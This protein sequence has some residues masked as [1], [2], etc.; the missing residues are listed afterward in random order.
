MDADFAGGL[1]DARST[2]GGYLVL[3]GPKTWFPLMW[4]CKKQSAT[5][6]STTEAEIVAL[7]ASLFPEAIP[8]LDLW[9]QL[10]GRP[11][12]LWILED[13][14]A[15]IKI[16]R[17]GYSQKLRSTSRVFNVN[18]GAISDAIYLDKNHSID[19]AYCHTEFQAAD[20]FT[21]ALAPQKWENAFRTN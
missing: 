3:A 12:E 17:K 21:K 8:Q 10:L 20:I 6:R 7:A 13:N 16:I 1:D 14:Q 4:L 2:S 9:E 19:I 15:T 18:V 11:V 5:A